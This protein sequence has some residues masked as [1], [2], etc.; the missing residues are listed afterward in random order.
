MDYRAELLE[1]AATIVNLTNHAYFNLAGEG[2]GDIYDHRLFLNADEL[3]PG[4]RDADPH[5]RHRLGARHADGLPSP[6]GDR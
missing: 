3:H 1:G 4:R 6:G 2:N 5:R